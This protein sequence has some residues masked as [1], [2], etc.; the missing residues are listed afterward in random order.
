LPVGPTVDCSTAG[1]VGPVCGVAGALAAELVLRIARGHAG[2]FG[3][4][5]T[6]DGR[7]DRLRRVEVRPRAECPLCGA[8]KAIRDIDP[9]RYAAPLCDSI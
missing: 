2:A 3:W 7:R 9:G 6:Y 5:H 8:P 1:I 4:I